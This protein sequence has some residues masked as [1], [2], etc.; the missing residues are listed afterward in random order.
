VRVEVDSVT[1]AF[2]QNVVLENFSAKFNAG[3]ITAL[4]GPSGSGKSTL[5]AAMGGFVKL[6]SGKIRLRRD[7]DSQQ[8]LPVRPEHI[9]WIPQGAN[10]LGARTVTDNV[11]IGVL[12]AGLS[13]RESRTKAHEALELVGMTH[14]RDALARTLSGGE[15]QRVAFARALA[16]QRPLILADEPTSSLDEENTANI[17]DLLHG[18]RANATV[19]VATHDPAVIGAVEEVVHLRGSNA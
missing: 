17:V 15:L 9:G 10:A 8:A 6:R 4:V 7:T 11:M 16:S 13:L 18:L 19:I 5:L 14:R 2:G 1:L 3:K 12:S